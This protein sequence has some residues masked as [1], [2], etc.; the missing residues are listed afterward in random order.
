MGVAFSL[1]AWWEERLTKVTSE[2]I[3]RVQ[4]NLLMEVANGVSE[5][6]GHGHSNGHYKEKRRETSEERRIR[7]EKE[8][9]AKENETEEERRIRKEREKREGKDKERRKETDEERKIRKE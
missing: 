8:R 2:P 6:N 3:F 1:S 5:M 4:A 9:R 7:K